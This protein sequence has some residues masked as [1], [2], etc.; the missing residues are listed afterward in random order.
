MG[1]F[2]A[3]A[4]RLARD[5]GVRVRTTAMCRHRWKNFDLE[6][7]RSLLLFLDSEPH[8]ASVCVISISFPFRDMSCVCVCV[9]VREH[10]CACEH[11][12]GVATNHGKFRM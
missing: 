9:Y 4:A 1:F 2:I 7:V 8:L 6:V 5:H 12:F 11:K 10:V 3:G